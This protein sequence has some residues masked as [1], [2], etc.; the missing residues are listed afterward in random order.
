MFRRA[1]KN[2]SDSKSVAEQCFSF[3]FQ[4]LRSNFFLV[5]L[6][7]CVPNAVSFFFTSD[8]QAADVHMRGSTSFNLS[9]QNDYKLIK[10]KQFSL[11]FYLFT[12]MSTFLSYSFDF[13]FSSPLVR[14]SVVA[15]SFRNSCTFVDIH[16]LVGW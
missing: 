12:L 2:T 9:Q 14:L 1:A 5:L 6:F 16:L 10:C 8:S 7:L 13:F 11:C 4:F 3:Y 15:V